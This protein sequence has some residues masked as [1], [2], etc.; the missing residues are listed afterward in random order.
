MTRTKSGA[1]TT[2][3]FVAA[4]LIVA[5][6]MPTGAASSS[7]SPKQWAGG[8]CSAVQTFAE[9]VDATISGLKGSA[10]LDSATQEAKSGLQSAVTELEGSLED[11][12]RPSTS[13]GKQ[14]QAAV[15]DLSDELSKNVTAIQE[16]LTPPP[17]TPSEIASTFADIGSQ[18]QKA[19][20][21]TKSTAETL[22]GLKSNGT[23]QKAFQSAPA[24]QEL[25]KSS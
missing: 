17:S 3:L 18:I 21:Q 16:S 24:C 23:L 11:L 20:S 14:A 6:A 13:D 19:V 10:S 5:W 2:G 12:G 8:V 4:V 25:K 1:H 22:K 9:S 7:T 15:Q